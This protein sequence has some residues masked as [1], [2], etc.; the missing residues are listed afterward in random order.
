[1]YRIYASLSSPTHPLVYI[2]YIY[3]LSSDGTSRLLIISVLYFACKTISSVGL[4]LLL[5]LVLRFRFR[6]WVCVWFC[7]WYCHH[8]HVGTTHFDAGS[9]ESF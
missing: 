3:V 6:F 8:L 5:G 1:M 2:M 4:G 9:M 7:F